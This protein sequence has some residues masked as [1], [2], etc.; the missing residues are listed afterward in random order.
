M[1]ND[2]EGLDLDWQV[3]TSCWGGKEIK[4][5]HRIKKLKV[6]YR[7]EECSSQRQQC[8]SRPWSERTER[9]PAWT[10]RPKMEMRL[11]MGQ[12]LGDPLMVLVFV[13]RL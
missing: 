8:M 9:R 11:E 13:K 12:G 4:F 5:Q 2:R 6:H 1:L 7:G 10:V 3:G